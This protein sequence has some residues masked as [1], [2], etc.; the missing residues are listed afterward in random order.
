MSAESLQVLADP[1][2]LA[3]VEAL[4]TQPSSVGLLAQSFPISRPAISRH[5]RL[6]KDAGLVEPVVEGTRHIYRVRPDGISALRAYMDELWREA[7][8]RYTMAAENLA[9]ENS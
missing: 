1:V 7:S 6:L 9:G 5:L 3:I 8:T 4:A 2:R